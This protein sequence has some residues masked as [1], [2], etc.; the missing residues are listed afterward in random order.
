MSACSN[1]PARLPREPLH[2]KSFFRRLLF[3][4][5]LAFLLEVLGTVS[6]CS[7]SIVDAAPNNLLSQN[8]WMS[9]YFQG[10]K[11][12]YYT[13]EISPEDTGFL[14]AESTF[15][16]MSILGQRRSIVLR[17]TCHVRDDL[18]LLDFT[19]VMDSDPAHYEIMGS[20]TD[21]GLLVR[22]INAAGNSEMTIP[23][24]GPL[25]LPLCI[26]ALVTSKGLKVGR[27]FVFSTFDPLTQ[28]LDSLEA[29]V[30][31]QET[32]S[33][34]VFT[35]TAFKLNI[36][37]YDIAMGL[38][39]DPEGRI[40]REESPPGMVLVADTPEGARQGMREND[41]LV[42]IARAT[43]VPVNGT[44]HNP[45]TTRH[46]TLRIQ[47]IDIDLFDV[48]GGR[49]KVYGDLV[50]IERENIENIPTL[51][52]PITDSR[53]LPYLSPEPYIQSTNPQIQQQAMEIIGRERDALRAARLITTW[54]FHN[55][56]KTPLLAVPNALEILRVKRGDCNEHAVLTAA[57][58]R[59]VGIPCRLI[60]GLVYTN[61]AFAYHAWNEAFVGE[62]IS[63]D[64]TFDQV[65]A[66][67]T[68]LRLIEGGLERQTRLMKIIGVIR[69]AVESSR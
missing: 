43:R 63:V 41:P 37:Q 10:A 7:Q 32:V 22:Y 5:A 2:A 34:P 13:F 28:K 9:I 47:G 24:A 27:S 20:V 51:T 62:W 29:R 44:I 42:D 6:P 33:S 61:G 58:M 52:L 15:L 19:F 57:L 4:L 12:G 46:L 60:T 69:L 11:I 68:H 17:T 48:S 30:E 56:Q 18:S 14:F 67:A 49:Q 25:Y 45:R 31:A 38:W 36:K 23:A 1:D 39:I 16:R 55:L 8:Q 21:K 40:V 66:D 54:T 64:A 35:G 65:P 26:P 53:F 59:S 3:F 50:D